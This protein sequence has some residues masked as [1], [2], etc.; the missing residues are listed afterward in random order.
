MQAGDVVAQAFDL[1]RPLLEFFARNHGR[2][3]FPGKIRA[4]L[5]QAAAD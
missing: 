5:Q 3:G 4:L 2:F 1:F